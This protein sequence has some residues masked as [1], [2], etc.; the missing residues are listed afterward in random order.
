MSFL[1]FLLEV[2]HEIGGRPWGYWEN[3]G[4][5]L[6]DL[7]HW[8]PEI[9][10]AVIYKEQ[11]Y[12]TGGEDMWILRYD[13]G[14]ARNIEI[15]QYVSEPYESFRRRV[16]E[17]I[18]A[19]KQKSDDLE[20]IKRKHR[21]TPIEM[22]MPPPH[23]ERTP[24]KGYLGSRAEP[25]DPPP[26]YGAGDRIY[27]NVPYGE[28]EIV[29]KKFYGRWDPKLKKWYVQAIYADIGEFERRGWM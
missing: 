7:S 26:G 12:R 9:T 29:K 22:G 10:D 23:P 18:L 5:K 3:Q 21:D 15:R 27:L 8:D 17:E 28:K 16:K 14:P 13:R 20:A 19:K 24:T 25:H 6:I 4:G 11:K 1:D 2:E